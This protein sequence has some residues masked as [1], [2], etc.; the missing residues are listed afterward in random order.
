[1]LVV[2]Y[3]DSAERILPRGRKAVWSSH[4]DHDHRTVGKGWSLEVLVL[5]WQESGGEP[6]WYYNDVLRE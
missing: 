6:P 1:M 5:V 4:A 3:N 2:C